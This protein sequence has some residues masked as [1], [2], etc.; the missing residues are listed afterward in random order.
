MEADNK[1][2]QQLQVEQVVAE[3]VVQVLLGKQVQLIQVAEEA[4]LAIVMIAVEQ[5]VLG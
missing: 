2:A 1:R 4:V 3:M 5:V